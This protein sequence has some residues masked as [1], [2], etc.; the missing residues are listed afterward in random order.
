ML[1]LISARVCCCCLSLTRVFCV[2]PTYGKRTIRSLS[3][4]RTNGINR[5]IFDRRREEKREATHLNTLII[6]RGVIKL[7]LMIRWKFINHEYT[8][9]GK[10][11]ETNIKLIRLTCIKNMLTGEK[12]KIKRMTRQISCACLNG[13][14]EVELKHSFQIDRIDSCTVINAI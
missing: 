4:I 13:G 10:T 6:K 14:I 2:L 7:S 3:Y 11:R 12:K 5:M 1:R 9:L 8:K